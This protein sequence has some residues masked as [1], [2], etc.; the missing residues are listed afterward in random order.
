MASDRGLWIV[1][2][3]SLGAAALCFAHWAGPRPTPSRDGRFDHDVVMPGLRQAAA[4]VDAACARGDAAAFA[5]ATTPAHRA[6]LAQRLR[7]VGGA[8]DGAALRAL[9]QAPTLD[10]FAA[11]P[12]AGALQGRRSAVALPLERGAQVMTFEW[13]GERWRLDGCHQ[14]P[15][16]RDAAAAEAA[17]ADAVARRR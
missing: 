7:G 10:H 13:D 8:L 3:A 15:S 16:V 1:A 6:A 9:A 14:A 5:A 12:L 2:C 4:A 11:P 17:V